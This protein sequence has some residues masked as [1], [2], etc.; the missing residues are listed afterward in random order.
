LRGRI[1]LQ[2]EALLVPADRL[3]FLLQRRDQA[4]EGS[5]FLAKLFRGLV[6][7]IGGHGRT[8]RP[9]VAAAVRGRAADTRR[10]PRATAPPRGRGGSRPGGGYSKVP[11]RHGS[12]AGSST[13]ARPLCRGSRPS[14]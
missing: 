10:C 13:S 2:R 8:L 9:R 3:R 11:S 1:L 6:V 4:G 14:R 7:L 5:S 12:T